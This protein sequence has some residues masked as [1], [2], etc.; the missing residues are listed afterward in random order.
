M[1]CAVSWP[2][3]TPFTKLVMAVL[4]GAFVL[5]ALLEG[6]T[7]V[8]LSAVLALDTQTLGVH[9][10][11]Q[12]PAWS[13]VIP[14]RQGSLIDA[15][16]ALFFAY[17]IVAPFDVRYGAR[18]ALALLGWCTLG[19]TLAAVAGGQ[20]LGL[21]FERPSDPLYGSSPALWG[22]LVGGLFASPGDRV[23]VFGRFEAKRWHILLVVLV[24]SSFP[25][26]QTRGAAVSSF[27]A[28]WG[29]VGAAVLW[30]RLRGSPKRPMRKPPARRPAHLRVI[31]GG[32][33]EPPKVLH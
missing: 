1:D 26:L 31:D 25:V 15:A 10:A 30:A 6:T 32:R 4:L 33:E 9:T 22:L 8:P 3:L 14:F 2:P 7:G 24:F 29:A 23:M 16:L 13:L 5:L 19:A 28:T 12:V 18:N 27:F 20:L 21:L 11:W 17:L